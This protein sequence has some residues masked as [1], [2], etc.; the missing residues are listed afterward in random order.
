M[1]GPT[2]PAWI[3]LA[4]AAAVAAAAGFSV[5]AWRAGGEAARTLRARRATLAD[6]RSVAAGAG[7]NLALRERLEALPRH[8]PPPLAELAR[9]EAPGARG[10]QVEPA[11]GTGAEGGWASRRAGV[12]FEE[13]RLEELGR[14]VAA[15]ERARPPWRLVSARVAA[16][17]PAPGV[18]RATLELEAWSKGDAP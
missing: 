7:R 2:R 4:A 10:V 15:C 6:I 18:A 3:V 12:F 17:G 14:F 16:G 1:T 11:A 5:W 8:A 13:V 9:R